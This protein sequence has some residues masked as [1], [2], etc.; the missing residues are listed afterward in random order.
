MWNVRVEFMPRRS[1]SAQA[2]E[3]AS[4]PSIFYLFHR[5]S[6]SGAERKSVAIR[7][8]LVSIFA[9]FYTI[10]VLLRFTIRHN[11]TIPRI[12]YR[13]KFSGV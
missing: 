4:L 6:K 5:V 10:S 7:L 1:T 8:K 13:S 9:V 2:W 11:E 3:I 12:R